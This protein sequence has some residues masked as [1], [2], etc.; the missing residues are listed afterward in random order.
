MS[1]IGKRLHL[2]E[3]KVEWCLWRLWVVREVS[4]EYPS[5]VCIFSFSLIQK[6]ANTYGIRI[7]QYTVS[8]IGK[9]EKRSTHA[10]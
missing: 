1:D 2:P 8:N 4:L 9:V 3:A 7:G 10:S 5:H 6:L